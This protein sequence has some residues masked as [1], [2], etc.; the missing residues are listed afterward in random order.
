VWRSEG[1]AQ[2]LTGWAIAG[3][4]RYYC[5]SD[6]K[7]AKEENKARAQRRGF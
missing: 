2:K 4:T 3:P 7:R 5:E 1:Q 6:G